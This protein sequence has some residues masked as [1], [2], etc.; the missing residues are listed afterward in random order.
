MTRATYVTNATPSRRAMTADQRRAHWAEV[1][2]GPE[3]ADWDWR[4]ELAQLATA[5]LEYL[6][7][8]AGPEVVPGLAAVLAVRGGGAARVC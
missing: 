3:Q 7:Q 5:S 6:G 8:I 1:P 4:P 2:T